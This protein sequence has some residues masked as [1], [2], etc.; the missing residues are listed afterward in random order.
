MLNLDDMYE[1]GVY[2]YLKY[3]KFGYGCCIDY[4]CKDIWIGRMICE[5]VVELV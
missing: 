2:D 1:N 3:I 5:K 4:V